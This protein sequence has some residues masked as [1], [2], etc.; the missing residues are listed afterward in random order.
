MFK[1]IISK[2]TTKIFLD[3]DGVLVDSNKYKEIAIE[4]SIKF[5]EKDIV[6]TKNSVD[7]FNANAGLAREG[8]LR[9]FFDQKKVD[10]IMEKYSEY[11]KQ[12]LLKA[13]L[14]TGSKEFITKISESYPNIELYILSG[15]EKDEIWNFL[16]RLNLLNKFTDLLCSEKSKLDHLKSFKL[17]ENDIFFGDSKNDLNVS[18]LFDLKFILVSDFNSFCS[19]PKQ[20]DLN[21]KIVIIKNLSYIDL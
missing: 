19:A 16:Q 8:K 17:N 3:F 13:D 15:A 14:T 5:Y 11:C 18:K 21:D 9:K 12:Y 10:D 1:R 4:K 7:F 20:A 6:I 2:N